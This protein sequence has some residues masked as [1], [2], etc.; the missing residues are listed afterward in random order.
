MVFSAFTGNSCVF[1]FIFKKYNPINDNV[2]I[3]IAWRKVARQTINK[4]GNLE[5]NRW[6]SDRVGVTMTYAS[7]IWSEHDSIMKFMFVSAPSFI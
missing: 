4:N 7:K 5:M 6:R 2:K 3:V 1:P